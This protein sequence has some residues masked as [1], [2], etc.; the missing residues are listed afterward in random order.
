VLVVGG[1]GRGWV[2]RTGLADRDVVRVHP[3][4]TVQVR[5]DAW[6]EQAFTGQVSNISSAAD[7]ATGTFQVEVRVEPGRDAF[8]QGLVAKVSFAPR[9]A[10]DAATAVVPVQALLEAN[11]DDASVFVVDLASHRARRVAVRIGRLSEGRVQILDGLRTGD[12]VVVAGAAFLADGDMVR[13]VAP[14]P[15]AAHAT[16]PMASDHAG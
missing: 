1:N 6:P 10:A 13:I 12:P 16:T 15:V 4:D 9:S 2:V 7:P 14:P 3:G 5:F 8:V 11:G